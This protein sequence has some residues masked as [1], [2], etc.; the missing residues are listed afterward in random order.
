MQKALKYILPAVFLLFSLLLTWGRRGTME[1]DGDVRPTSSRE[2]SDAISAPALEM[3]MQ[4]LRL[5]GW[6]VNRFQT[7]SWP[8]HRF[9]Y[10]GA[11][12]VW[13]FFVGVEIDARLNGRQERW[14]RIALK[15]AVLL[16]LSWFMIRAGAPA[17]R[18]IF[19]PVSWSQGYIVWSV[20]LV[21]Y[22]VV[23]IYLT[24]SSRQRMAEPSR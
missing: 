21:S 11:V 17:W 6:Y 14:W 19:G 16:Y 2:L 12:I 3:Y 8:D 10:Y 18:D 13:W 15:I 7:S 22:C 4:T 24:L 5:E 9:P 20:C 1:I 23:L